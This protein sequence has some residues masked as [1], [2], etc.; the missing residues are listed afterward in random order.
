MQLEQETPGSPELM[1]GQ[2]DDG[3]DTGLL[4]ALFVTE[5]REA[6]K[7]LTVLVSL[8][9]WRDR[10][11]DQ[12][13]L[14]VSFVK[15]WAKYTSKTLANVGVVPWN[16]IEGY[17]AIIQRL[18]WEISTMEIAD[19]SDTILNAMCAC[20]KNERLLSPMMHLMLNRAK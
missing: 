5:D 15:V 17:T 9:K 18:M 20:V 16:N 2:D 14:R 10:F 7:K 12:S 11:R 8:G 6:E 1:M 4:E 3:V 19:Y 13:G